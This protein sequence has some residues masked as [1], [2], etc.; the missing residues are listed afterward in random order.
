[1]AAYDFTG[2]STMIAVGGGHCLPPSCG[3]IRT[4]VASCSTSLPWLRVRSF[5][6]TPP[7]SQP[8]TRVAGDFLQTLPNGGDAYIFKRAIHD[9][10]LG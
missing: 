8:C 10:Q 3:P 6:W 1:M 9:P 2:L 7:A 5:S 4:R